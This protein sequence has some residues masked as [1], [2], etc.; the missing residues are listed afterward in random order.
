MW[1]LVQWQFFRWLELDSIWSLPKYEAIVELEMKNCVLWVK[2]IVLISFQYHSSLLFFS[3]KLSQALMELQ[4]HM[5]SAIFFSSVMSL[6][7]WTPVV[8]EALGVYSLSRSR[9]PLHGNQQIFWEVTWNTF[10][11]LFRPL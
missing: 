1:C 4:G 11:N 9:S 10:I 8:K 2:V 5:I 7:K 3:K 6:L